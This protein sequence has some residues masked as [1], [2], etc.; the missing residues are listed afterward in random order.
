MPN[1]HPYQ[2]QR[3]CPVQGCHPAAACSK[4]WHHGLLAETLALLH[5][6][7][8]FFFQPAQAFAAGQL[9]D[10][11]GGCQS[12]VRQRDHAVK[13]QIGHFIDQLAGI[14]AVVNVLGG[15]HGFSGFFANFLQKSVGAF[16]QQTGYVAFFR[17]AAVDRLAAFDDGGQTRQRVF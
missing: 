8:G 10:H 14:T 12:I 1:K 17:I 7:Q 13:P 16:V 6:A 15:H 3:E 11:I 5:F 2:T 9:I 4:P